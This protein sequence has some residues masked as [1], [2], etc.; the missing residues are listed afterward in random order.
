MTKKKRKHGDIEA[1]RAVAI[2]AAAECTERGV[3]V[4]IGDHLTAAQRSGVERY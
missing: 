4:R 3:V 1:E 2:A